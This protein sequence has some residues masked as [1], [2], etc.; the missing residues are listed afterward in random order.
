MPIKKVDLKI[1][2]ARN[3]ELEQIEMAEDMRAKPMH[4]ICAL[5]SRLKPNNNNIVENIGHSNDENKNGGG[6][7]NSR[8]RSKS[9]KRLN[10]NIFYVYIMDK[11]N[12]FIYNNFNFET[13]AMCIILNA[14]TCCTYIP[15][16]NHAQS[17]E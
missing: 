5:N 16:P 2:F 11:T 7:G 4:S 10:L 13:P 14:H 15:N 8:N 3:S 1:E 9:S 17:L 6:G 12:T